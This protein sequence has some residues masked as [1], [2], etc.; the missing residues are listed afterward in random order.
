MAA[1]K[2]AAS[3]PSCREKG[4]NSD[5][6]K[7]KRENKQVHRRPYNAAHQDGSKALEI[8]CSRGL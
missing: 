5:T 1:G 6:N 4:I 7:C 3:P 2:I 8:I